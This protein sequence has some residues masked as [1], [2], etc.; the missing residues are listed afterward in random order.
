MFKNEL[1][2]TGSYTEQENSTS[3]WDW[4]WALR[5]PL[6]GDM[7]LQREYNFSK[8]TMIHLTMWPAKAWPYQSNGMFSKLLCCYFT[9]KH[10][11]RYT[12]FWGSKRC[13]PSSAVLI[14]LTTGCM[15]LAP[16]SDGLSRQVDIRCN[17]CQHATNGSFRGANTEK[18]TISL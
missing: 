5:C 11:E 16:M 7:R 10:P 2:K 12:V 9:S 15:W 1:C 3:C 14:K 17:L 8:Q 13:F 4:G 18:L 6:S